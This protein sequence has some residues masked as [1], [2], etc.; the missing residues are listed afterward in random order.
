M[1]FPTPTLLAVAI[2]AA[3]CGGDDGGQGPGE[4]DE[5]QDRTV[6]VR[7]NSFA[8]TSLTVGA[9]TTVVWTWAPGSAEHN[10]TFD[11]A[12]SPTQSSGT[13]SRAFAEPG[14]YEYLCT[15]HGAGMSGVINVTDA[16]PSTG[17][18]SGGPGNG[19]D[20]YPD[21]Y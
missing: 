21:G 18:G 5:S 14:E 20:G 11:D 17:D 8:P 9:G 1:R 7:N 16:E 3:A 10:V 2:A 12:S 19:G 15:I 13:F 4:G 6:T